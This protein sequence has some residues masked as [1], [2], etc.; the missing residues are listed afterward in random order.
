[1]YPAILSI[2][3][4]VLTV[5][6][7]RS[8]PPRCRV[9]LEPIGGGSLRRANLS[10]SLGVIVVDRAAGPGTS[11][12]TSPLARAGRWCRGSTRTS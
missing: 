10:P 2:S 12:V 3:A 1:V 5:A 8:A 11:R 6:A 7:G 4:G 9:R